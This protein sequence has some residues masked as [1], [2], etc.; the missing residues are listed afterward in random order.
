VKL[1]C[2]LALQDSQ[3][4]GNVAPELTTA[5]DDRLGAA[6]HVHEYDAVVVLI[7]LTVAKPF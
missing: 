1:V 2:D 5:L 4:I 6:E 7:Y 3:R